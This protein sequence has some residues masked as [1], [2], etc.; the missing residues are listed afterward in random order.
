MIFEIWLIII[1]IIVGGFF[2]AMWGISIRI[3]VKYKDGDEGE[4]EYE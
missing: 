3:W 4:D 2:F 1:I